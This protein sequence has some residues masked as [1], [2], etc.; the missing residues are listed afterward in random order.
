MHWIR[1]W[2][3]TVQFHWVK[4]FVECTLHIQRARDYHSEHVIANYS[5]F[6]I[7]DWHRVINFCNII[8]DKRRCSSLT[9]HPSQSTLF[10]VDSSAK[11]NVYFPNTIIQTTSYVWR[12]GSIAAK[13]KTNIANV[14][15]VRS[16]IYWNYMRIF[17]VPTWR[18]Q[19]A[20]LNS[21]VV[22][23]YAPYSLVVY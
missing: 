23:M 16:K 18:S 17:N 4:I 13:R 9:T 8:E 3:C 5:Q 20:L 22:C 11:K 15:F 1:Q 12:I 21:F 14:R 19:L 7:S 2:A 10:C 6:T